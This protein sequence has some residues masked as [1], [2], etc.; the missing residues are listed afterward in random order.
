[1]T[2]PRIL[3]VGTGSGCIA[4]SVA[5]QHPGAK[6]LAVDVSPDA[7][8]LAGR[9]A[10]RHGV[11]GRVEFRRSNLFA[12]VSADS[13]FEFILSNP[14]YIPTADI[15]GLAPEVRD[16]E[17]RLALDGGPGGFAV[18]DRLVAEA[19]TRLSRGGWLMIEVGADQESAA[20]RR[21]SELEGLSLAPTVRDGDGQPRVVAAQ[22]S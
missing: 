11:A 3:D 7:L 19:P 12:A 10:E 20:R 14:P 13:E 22:R 5:K 2:A 9:N 6:V 8:E 17:P 21:L 18:F 4:V 1:M 15:A 16:H